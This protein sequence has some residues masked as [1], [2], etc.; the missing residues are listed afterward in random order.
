MLERDIEAKLRDYE[1]SEKDGAECA[2][3]LERHYN[4]YILKRNRHRPLWVKQQ[5][6]ARKALGTLDE[7]LEKGVITDERYRIRAAKHEP[8]LART[9]QQLN[10]SNT[11]AERWL[12]L[13]NRCLAALLIWEMYLR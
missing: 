3:W 9:E 12:E 11:D 5:L 13:A 7:K 10:N 4:D 6:E 2:M 1:I 8:T